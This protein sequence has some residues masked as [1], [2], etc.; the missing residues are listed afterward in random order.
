L[1]SITEVRLQGYTR[2]ASLDID[3][4]MYVWDSFAW[5]GSLWG[6]AAFEWHVPRWTNDA[7]STVDPSTRTEAGLNAFSVLAHYYTPDGS[8]M[9]DADLDCLKLIVTIQTGGQVPVPSPAYELGVGETMTPAPAVWYL[10]P[11]DVGKWYTTVEMQYLYNY[12]PRF[13][14]VWL[15]GS[16][17]FTYE[18][19]CAL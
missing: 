2:S 19:W 14:A 1:D 12:D 11:G 15:S 7:V 5:L 13:P 16:T 3:F 10:L 9:G 4:D 17:T 6:N 8:P 18:W